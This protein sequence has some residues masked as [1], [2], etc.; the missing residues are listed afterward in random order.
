M[1]TLVI[2]SN[3]ELQDHLKTHHSLWPLLLLPLPAK[4]IKLD[5]DLKKV[6]PLKVSWLIYMPELKTSD[7]MAMVTV[8]N[9]QLKPKREDSMLTKDSLK[10]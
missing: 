4:P 5:K 8:L 7:L 6:K 1:L 3:S 9:G 2:N 10:F